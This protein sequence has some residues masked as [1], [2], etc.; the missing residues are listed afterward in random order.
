[1]HSALKG[2]YDVLQAFC[3]RCHSFQSGFYIY[4]SLPRFIFLSVPHCPCTSH[5]L[6][7]TLTHMALLLRT[8]Q[9]TCGSLVTQ[10]FSVNALEPSV[11]R[12]P[13]PTSSSQFTSCP[14]CPTSAPRQAGLLSV[15]H[16]AFS[17]SERWPDLRPLSSPPHPPEAT[18]AAQQTRFTYLPSE[19]SKPLYFAKTSLLPLQNSRLEFL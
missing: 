7:Q 1:M 16:V 4:L 12:V 15:H 13:P 14:V 2:A 5:A 10:K 8:W 9:S 3:P 17:H 19:L 6:P 11:Q 18:S